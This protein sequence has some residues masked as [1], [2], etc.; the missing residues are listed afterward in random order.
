MATTRKGW[1]RIVVDEKDYRWMVKKDASYFSNI[2]QNNMRFVVESSCGALLVV[3]LNRPRLDYWLYPQS[4]EQMF[5]VTPHEVAQEI[6]NALREG[7]NSE[8]KGKPSFRN[9]MK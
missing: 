7:W 6:R 9:G 3:E 8:V 2:H 1:R 5:P 4:K